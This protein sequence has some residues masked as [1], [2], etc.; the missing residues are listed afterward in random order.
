MF[1]IKHYNYVTLLIYS[2]LIYQAVK[3]RHCNVPI[4]INLLNIGE[5]LKR[6]EYHDIHKFERT[7]FFHKD[8]RKIESNSYK[9]KPKLP[10]LDV[11]FI[12]LFIQT[13]SFLLSVDE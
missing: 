10:G 3:M 6:A 8:L 12:P 11:T 4:K 13:V 5:A 2:L 9:I 7:L 1:I